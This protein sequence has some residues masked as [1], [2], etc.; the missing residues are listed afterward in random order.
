[1]TLHAV[2]IELAEANAL[3]ESWHRHHK[4]AVGHRFSIGVMD[5]EG[6]LH[7]AAIIGRPVARMVSSRDV[8]EVT[9]LVTDGT[10]NACS[11][12]YA[13]SA[14][15]AAAGGYKRIQTYILGDETGASL[16]AA[17]WTYEGETGGGDWNRPSRGDRR[18]DQP[19]T[20]K[21]RWSKTLSER[22]DLV[23]DD[24]GQLAFALSHSAGRES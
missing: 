10:K 20:I 16:R 12:L 19:M 4:P 23:T 11:L 22:P 2:H 17:G 6:V 15:M 1:V 5:D 13:A 21:G 3:V 18:T 7:G 9:R 14:R 8:A 24:E